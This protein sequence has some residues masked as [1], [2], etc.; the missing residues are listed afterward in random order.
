MPTRRFERIALVQI[1]VGGCAVAFSACV[2][3]EHAQAQNRHGI[4]TGWIAAP[5]IEP[6]STRVPGVFHLAASD[7][8]RRVV[9]PF[10][11][12][13]MWYAG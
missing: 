6:I 10:H 9:A 8:R 2:L 5:G 12:S 7:C 4:G 13:S 3:I 1:L 11:A